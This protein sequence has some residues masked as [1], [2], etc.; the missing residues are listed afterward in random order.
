MQPFQEDIRYPAETFQ[1]AIH[2]PLS[3]SKGRWIAAFNKPNLHTAIH[4][5]FTT[6]INISTTFFKIGKNN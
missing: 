2:C 6:F 5:L 4:Y 1:K 3:N